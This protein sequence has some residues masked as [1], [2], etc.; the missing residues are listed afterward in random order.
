MA[1][2][3][4][5]DEGEELRAQMRELGVRAKSAAAALALAATEA[6]NTALREAAKAIRA[7]KA[8]IVSANAKDMEEASALTGALRDRLLLN[9]ARIEA[10]RTWPRFPIRSAR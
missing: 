9:D 10:W 6:K 1:V 4:R 7:R 5:R 3:K 2:A 8:E